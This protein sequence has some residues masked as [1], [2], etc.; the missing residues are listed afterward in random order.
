[1]NSRDY[2]NPRPE[3]AGI[4]IDARYGGPIEGR[5]SGVHEQMFHKK[6]DNVII[7]NNAFLS[8]KAGFQF[9][10][11][12]NTGLPK[13]ETCEKGDTIKITF[14][15]ASC[16][17]EMAAKGIVDWTTAIGI[18]ME[19]QPILGGG[20]IIV[21]DASENNK[22]RVY[23]IGSRTVIDMDNLTYKRKHECDC[24]KEDDSVDKSE[25]VEEFP[26]SG[27]VEGEWAY[28]EN[29]YQHNHCCKPGNPM[30]TNLPHE[31]HHHHTAPHP[32]AMPF[33][34]N[35]GIELGSNSITL[36]DDEKRGY[37]TLNVIYKKKVPID[38]LFVVCDSAGN[39]IYK[40][41]DTSKKVSSYS[42]FNW[43]LRD[44][45]TEIDKLPIIDK[46]NDFSVDRNG[47]FIMTQEA[48]ND[49]RILN[50]EK[51]NDT[52]IKNLS[53]TVQL[54]TMAQY[55][56]G[57]LLDY[58]PKSYNRCKYYVD[59]RRVLIDQKDILDAMYAAPTEPKPEEPSPSDPGTEDN[60]GGDNTES[61]GDEGGSGTDTNP[62]E[63]IETV[64]YSM[65]TSEPTEDDNV[66]ITDPDS[67]KELAVNNIYTDAD[68]C[69]EGGIVL[70]TY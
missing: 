22:S 60:T 33:K 16:K 11:S 51:S 57:S 43:T 28:Q 10:S 6:N 4:D 41:I 19:I 37:K 39:V 46:Y 62:D 42:I 45:I 40:A 9:M 48:K 52:L 49:E 54:V 3:F 18:V 15:S 47:K 23:R 17:R 67:G 56:M 5:H 66:R 64:S 70:S 25:I 21:L 13:F 20:F 69:P 26:E 35:P 27:C 34:K 30:D 38:V 32:N 2:Y 12:E 1:M 59:G 50:I 8:Y 55:E 61:G 53:F 63:G 31:H 29:P 7:N 58:D 44:Y 14:N 68:S 24:D 65:D 36:H